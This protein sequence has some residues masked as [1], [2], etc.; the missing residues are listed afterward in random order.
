LIISLFWIQYHDGGQIA[1]IYEVNKGS[2]PQ[3][4]TETF[5]SPIQEMQGGK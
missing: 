2:R 4:F 1:H 5:E 3:D